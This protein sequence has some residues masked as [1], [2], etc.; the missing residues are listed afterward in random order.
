MIGMITVLVLLYVSCSLFFFLYMFLREGPRRSVKLVEQLFSD[1]DFVT[2]TSQIW[3]DL[4][5]AQIKKETIPG[6]IAGITDEI[7]SVVTLDGKTITELKKELS[8]AVLEQ[9]NLWFGRQTQAVRRAE[10][11]ELS[12][13]KEIAQ[14]VT[15]NADRPDAIAAISTAI[16]AKS[17]VLGAALQYLSQ[18]QGE[19]RRPET[20]SKGGY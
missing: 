16:S 14:Y 12:D 20:N 3:R 4:I 8:H 19:T 5:V 18:Q 17:P 1:V 13:S 15:M 6:I 2:G 9:W 7:T 10:E 11:A